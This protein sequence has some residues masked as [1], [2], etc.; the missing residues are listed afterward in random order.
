MVSLQCEYQ[1]SRHDKLFSLS[2][3]KYVTSTIRK[4]K[5]FYQNVSNLVG[6]KI[7]DPMKKRQNLTVTT[8]V[9]E[10]PLV[11]AICL[12]ARNHCQMQ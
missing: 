12:P 11:F 2:M 5:N 6:G 9:H 7:A 3:R 4:I 1:T 8:V 10:V